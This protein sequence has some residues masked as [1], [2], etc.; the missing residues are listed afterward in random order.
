M[1]VATLGNFSATFKGDNFCEFVCF[2]EHQDPS[3]KDQLWSFKGSTL[4]RIYY[5]FRIEA[6]QEWI[7]F[8]TEVWYST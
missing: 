2:P 6:F 7:S 4:K 1:G 8:N 5:A 3:E